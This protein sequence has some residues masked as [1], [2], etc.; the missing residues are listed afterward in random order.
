M[1]SHTR[2]VTGAGGR[3]PRVLPGLRLNCHGVALRWIVA[4]REDLA[5][6]LA[7]TSTTFAFCSGSSASRPGP[8]RR[9]REF[10]RRLLDPHVSEPHRPTCSGQEPSS[11][12]RR[13]GSRAGP[14]C[15]RGRSVTCRYPRQYRQHLLGDQGRGLNEA[16]RAA[17]T[18]TLP[19]VSV[20]F[21]GRDS[22][23]LRR[24]SRPRDGPAAG[25]GGGASSLRQLTS[26]R[27]E[28]RRCSALRGPCRSGPHR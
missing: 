5:A 3:P 1:S 11:R 12:T 9:P 21:A 17:L 24:P 28:R 19:S 22:T 2:G 23:A 10:L 14:D 25:P 6:T 15:L 16:L 7:S 20:A 18:G 26:A 4:S 27:A 13:M 8:T